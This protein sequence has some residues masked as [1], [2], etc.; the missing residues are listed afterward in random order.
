M[1][2]LQGYVLFSSDRG[3]MR[4]EYAKNKMGEVS[5]QTI[6]VSLYDT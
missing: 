4:I 3:G 6:S 1:N 5:Q 2:A